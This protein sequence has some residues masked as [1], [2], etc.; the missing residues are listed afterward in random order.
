MK[1]RISAARRVHGKEEKVQS[2]I[3]EYYVGEDGQLR[4]FLSGTV[5]GSA[6]GDLTVLAGTEKCIAENLMPVRDHVPVKTLLMLDNSRSVRDYASLKEMVRQLILGHTG[7]EEF[8]LAAFDTGVHFVF[9]ED[10]TFSGDY[11]SLLQALDALAQEDLSTHVNRSLLQALEN[12]VQDGSMARIVLASDGGDAGESSP[13]SVQ[14]VDSFL[15]NKP[16]IL[17]MLGVPWSSAQAHG[18]ED[19]AYLGR[20][21]GT[22]QD[23]SPGNEQE[24]L[25]ELGR[26]YDSWYADVHVPPSAQDGSVKS[27]MVDYRS[28]DNSFSISR[29]IRM[30]QQ[31]LPEPTVS[32]TPVPTSTPAPTPEPEATE[33]PAAYIDRNPGG[34]PENISL[35]ASPAIIGG[36]AVLILSAIFLAVFLILRA[37]KRKTDEVRQEPQE[38]PDYDETEIYSEE[39]DAD[40]RDSYET[41]MMFGHPPEER[42]PE[43]CL[44]DVR[45]PSR[46]LKSAITGSIIVGSSRRS[47]D[48]VIEGDPTVSRKHACLS[49]EDGHLRL[50]DLGSTNGTWTNRSRTERKTEVRNGDLVRFGDSEFTVMLTVQ[51][52]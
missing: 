11:E 19:M 27:V 30:P 4:L 48:L 10:G 34:F 15:Q 12:T 22:Y 5:P 7:N 9:P 46:V 35:P 43:L 52:T 18:L 50:E 45:D 21:Y 20:K 31:L 16:V 42:I 39:E 14:E 8:C 29:D 49:L 38:F 13:V 51:G 1:L 32:P 23:Y 44:T 6:D 37:K 36:A 17:H 26:D 3:S 25:S 40:D 41:Q 2:A 47:S 24:I 33:I 28:A